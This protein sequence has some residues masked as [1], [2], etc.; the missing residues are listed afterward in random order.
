[1][2]QLPDPSRRLAAPGPFTTV[3]W[4]VCIIAA[5]GFAFDTYVLLMNPLILRPALAELLHV[6]PLSKDPAAAR[7]ANDL[8]LRWTGYVMWGSALCG[9]IFGMLG[10]YLTDRLGR[11]R[12]LTW[13]I[14]LYA[15]SSAAGAFVTSAEMLL[16]WRCMTFIGVCVEFVAAVAWLSE[17]FPQ[18]RRRE[19]VLGYTQAFA[20]TGGLLVS[21][22][23]KA[24][25][26]LAEPGNL[27]AWLTL[28]NHAA[29]WRYAL[30]SGL[31]PAI[32]LIIIRPFLPESPEWR[33]KKQAGKLQRPSISEIFQPMFRRT[34]IV[35]AILFACAFG[36]AFGAIQLTP[37]M[38]PGLI[39]D[40][41]ASANKKLAT[42]QKGSA[43]FDD[44]TK[45][46]TYLKT[47]PQQIVGNVQLIQ[48][49]GGLIGRIV[50]AW[51]ALR[52]LSR[53]KLLRLFLVPGLL[54]IPLVYGFAAAGH[55]G[56]MSLDVLEIGMFW[57]GF[58]TVAQFSFFGN[59]LPRMYPTHI[60]GTGESFSANVGGRMI[61]TGANF[62]TTQLAVALPFMM[63]NPDFARPAALAYSAAA[64]VAVVYGV[65]VVC[66]FWLPEPKSEAL[67]E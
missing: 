11:R 35:T 13:S 42:L 49:I 47:N 9:G 1:M 14:L 66:S 59:Y 28:P 12:V 26:K 25:Y 20:S 41:V 5:I 18:P 58:F 19:A 8:I 67:P 27:P 22:V 52:I 33:E 44:L 57:T 64:V 10:G 60:R 63:H 3:Q 29:G 36:A 34:T 2:N 45:Q 15:V 4:L 46:I 56:E 55:L 38:V 6:D 17:L 53:Q 50:L 32:P 24:S 48:E 30:I 40:Q 65:G 51:L 54:V 37:Q 21:L 7:L 39:K 31:I 23:F 62:V 43:E 61:G 16:F